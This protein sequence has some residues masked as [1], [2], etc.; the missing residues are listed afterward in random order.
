[1]SVRL[2]SYAHINVLLSF[3]RTQH[4]ALPAPWA[5]ACGLVKADTIEHAYEFGRELVRENLR[6]FAHCYGDHPPPDRR[7]RCAASYLDDY[8]F[9]PD[10]AG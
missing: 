6:A 1:M 5:P 8:C 7:F 2:V 4:L 3:A 10:P 9:D